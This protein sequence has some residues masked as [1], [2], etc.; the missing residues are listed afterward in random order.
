MR[1]LLQSRFPHSTMVQ[2]TAFAA[3]HAYKPFQLR[4]NLLLGQGRN[5][6]SGYTGC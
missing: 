5:E 2:Q 6:V 3:R 4:S 1:K